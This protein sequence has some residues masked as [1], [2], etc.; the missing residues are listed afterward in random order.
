M[1]WYTGKTSMNKP[2]CSA[3]LA[4]ISC[5][6]FTTHKGQGVCSTNLMT[7]SPGFSEYN[8]N[9]KFT[10]FTIFLGL[11]KNKIGKGIK[12]IYI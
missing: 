7:K 4:V 6:Q 10:S 2:N 5:F 11:P 12:S 8:R 1:S 3:K 9:L